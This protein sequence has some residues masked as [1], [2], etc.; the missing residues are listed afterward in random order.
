M[1]NIEDQIASI[2]KQLIEISQKLEKV[3]EYTRI[4]SSNTEQIITKQNEKKT[5]NTPVKAASST[6][7]KIEQFTQIRPY[8]NTMWKV[9]HNNNMTG[10][11]HDAVKKMEQ[12]GEPITDIVANAESILQHDEKSD[13][14]LNATITELWRIISNNDKWKEVI[15]GL[16]NDYNNNN[17]T[18]NNAELTA[19]DVNDAND[20]EKKSTKMPAKRNMPAKPATKPVK[21]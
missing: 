4:C 14:R 8:F 20:V 3:Y 10:P 1:S 17:K 5:R 13:K 2:S 11:I 19:N 9:E 18:V 16:K 12:N 21:K 7:V 6:P 15:N